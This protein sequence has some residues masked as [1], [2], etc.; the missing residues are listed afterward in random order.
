MK[1]I[2]LISL[3][4]LFAVL[5][6]GCFDIDE[7]FW[8]NSDGSVRMKL[9]FGMSEEFFAMAGEG[10]VQENPFE[11][12]QTETTE[13]P[14]VTVLDTSEYSEEGMRHMVVDVK[15]DDYTVFQDLAENDSMDIQVRE[16]ENGNVEFI[17][18]LDLS[19]GDTGMDTGEFDEMGEALAATMFADMYYTVTVHA[20]DVVS[21][22]GQVNNANDTVTWNVSM[23]ELLG[24][25]RELRAEVKTSGSSINWYIV[26][27]VSLACL[28]L[29]VIVVGVVVFLLLR[30]RGKKAEADG[31]DTLEE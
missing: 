23:T 2:V 22:N 25:S 11:D 15:F 12:L 19:T 29:L 18:I 7:E 8:F 26:A 24:G 21:S 10:E 5:L 16:L 28:C 1:K 20:K 3:F 4:I 30:S 31:E 9:D 14:K 13:H 6:T 27:G 17:Q